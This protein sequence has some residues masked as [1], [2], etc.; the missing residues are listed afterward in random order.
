M[1]AVLVKGDAVGA[2]LYYGQGAGGEPTASAVV[3]D[4]VDVT[5]LHTA[6][7][8]HRVPHLAFQPNSL[9]DLP[10]LPVSEVR[11]SYYLRLR[12]QDKPGV[13]A[14]ITG[15]LADGAISIDSMVQRGETGSDAADIIF[16]T[17]EAVEREV[18]AAIARI[19]A[20]P[21]VSSRVT[22]LRLERLA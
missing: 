15:I 17:H 5:R 13:M 3:A 8:G 4:L 10:I 19:E 14:E 20:L 7:P 1:N 18:D 16:L 12:V 22:R 2:T 9:S 11:T 6:D 21:T